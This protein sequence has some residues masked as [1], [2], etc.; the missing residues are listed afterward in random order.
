[1]KYP[2]LLIQICNHMAEPEKESD[3]YQ[4]MKDF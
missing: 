2:E 1:M 4:N 3:I